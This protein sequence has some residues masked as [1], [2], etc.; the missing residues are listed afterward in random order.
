VGDL[1]YLIQAVN[2]SEYRVHKFFE[3]E[4]MPDTTYKVTI[5]NGKMGCSCPSGVYRGYCKHS[6]MVKKY[7]ELEKTSETIPMLRIEGF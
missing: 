3:G 5:K 6:N 4:D 1:Y 2:S 7:R